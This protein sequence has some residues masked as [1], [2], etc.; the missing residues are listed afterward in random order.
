ML[1]LCSQPH[2]LSIYTRFLLGFLLSGR[3][4]SCRH[5]LLTHDVRQFFLVGVNLCDTPNDIYFIALNVIVN[6]F[7]SGASS[8]K[9]DGTEEAGTELN[10]LRTLMTLRNLLYPAAF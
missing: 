3:F 2:V 5:H 9:H 6:I 1:S 7:F 4:L 8:A 10:F